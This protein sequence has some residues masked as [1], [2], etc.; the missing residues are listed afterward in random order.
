MYNS[1]VLE[2][3]IAPKMGL[4]FA[5]DIYLELDRR[6][7]VIRAMDEHNIVGYDDVNAIFRAYSDQGMEGIPKELR[8]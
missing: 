4:E 7:R 3:K 5:K 8:R 6:E 1:Y 2:H